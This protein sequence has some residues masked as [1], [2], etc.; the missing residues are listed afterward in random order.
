MS[1]TAFN[2]LKIQKDNAHRFSGH[3]LQF[4]TLVDLKCIPFKSYLVVLCERP[5]HNKIKVVKVYLLT[6][7]GNCSK[8]E[9]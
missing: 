7:G 8:G 4:G 6:Y 5:L 2:M 3:S 9:E 1:T